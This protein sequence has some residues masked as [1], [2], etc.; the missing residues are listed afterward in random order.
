ML[1]NI[2]ETDHAERRLFPHEFSHQCRAAG[3]HCAVRGGAGAGRYLRLQDHPTGHPH[4]G[5]KRIH[6]VPGAAPVAERPAAHG[7]RCA[8][9]WPQPPLLSDHLR[10]AGAACRLRAGVEPLPFFH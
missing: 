2:I 8:L 4:A 7:L 3:R 5:A 9:Q 10:W 1:Y 6:P